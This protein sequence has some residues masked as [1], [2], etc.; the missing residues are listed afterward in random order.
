MREFETEHFGVELD[1]LARVLAAE[2]GV[3]QLFAEHSTLPDL[4]PDFAASV[5][6]AITGE[7]CRTSRTAGW[8]R[9]Q[10]PRKMTPEGKFGCHMRW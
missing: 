9:N 2:C 10:V 4:H 7:P 5:L 1:G 8:S 6:A 3:M